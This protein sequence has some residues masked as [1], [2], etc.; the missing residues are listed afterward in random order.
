MILIGFDNLVW[1]ILNQKPIIQNDHQKVS[2]VQIQRNRSHNILIN[3][4]CKGYF[5]NLSGD[6]T[7]PQRGGTRAW[8]Y[9]PEFIP[10]S[11]VPKCMTFYYYMFERTIDSAGP[12]LGS[13]RVYVKTV[14][15]NGESM[16]L[17][18]RLNNHQAQ[19]WKMAKVPITIGP[20]MKT[21]LQNYQII[22]EGIW[23]DGRVGTIAVDD[24]SFFNGNC[25]SKLKNKSLNYLK[26]INY[27]LL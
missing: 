12:S 7:Q 27:C 17:I 24:I 4:K 23:G 13:L 10:Q 14:T 8:I 19:A 22:I 20:E 18:W 9:S 1:V 11:T 6:N 3:K 21:P 26:S 25:T 2:N 16:S 15:D 5:I